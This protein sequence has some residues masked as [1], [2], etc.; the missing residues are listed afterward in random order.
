MSHEAHEIYNWYILLKNFG[1]KPWEVND[2]GKVYKEDLVYMIKLE[3][4]QNEA[5][6]KWENAESGRIIRR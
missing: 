6:R 5:A 3:E 2:T 1:I 4:F